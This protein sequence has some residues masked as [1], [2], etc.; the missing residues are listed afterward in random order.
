[1]AFQGCDWHTAGST[2][3]DAKLEFIVN[4]HPCRITSIDLVSKMLVRSSKVL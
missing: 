2:E 4:A 3:E 1:M